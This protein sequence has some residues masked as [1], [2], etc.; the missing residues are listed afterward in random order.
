MRGRTPPKRVEQHGQPFARLSNR[1]EEAESTV[2]PGPTGRGPGLR[3]P[4]HVGHRLGM[5]S[6]AAEMF[7]D[8]SF[9]AAATHNTAVEL[10]PI[11]HCKATATSPLTRERGFGRGKVPDDRSA[12][13]ETNASRDSDSVSG[14]CRCRDVEGALWDPPPQ[15]GVLTGTKTP[16][17]TPTR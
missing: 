4:T 1:A 6:I 8:R 13:V 14:S 3:E 17:V 10:F 11:C 7:H 5:S 9:P 16:A 12:R 15:T 2:A